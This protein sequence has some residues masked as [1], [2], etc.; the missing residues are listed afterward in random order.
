MNLYFGEDTIG[1]AKLLIV[2][3]ETQ[4]H[5]ITNKLIKIEVDKDKSTEDRVKS[6]RDE[7]M[8]DNNRKLN[9]T[10]GGGE[11]RGQG[12]RAADRDYADSQV[13]L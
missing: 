8:T 10:R 12:R 1:K 7:R 4:A 2:E 9:V 13:S 6:A 5:L 11:V 3:L